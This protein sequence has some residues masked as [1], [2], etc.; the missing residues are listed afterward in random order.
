MRPPEGA[1]CRACHGQRWWTEW[2]EPKGWRCMS[3]HPP[4]H[5]A[6]DQVKI[7]G[8]LFR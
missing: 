1:W 5:L 8:G 3:C 2:H 7:V 4:D 6:R